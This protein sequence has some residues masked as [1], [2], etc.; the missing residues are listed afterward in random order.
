MDL[1]PSLPAVADP[2]AMVPVPV[3]IPVPDLS[4]AGRSESEI[5]MALQR[6]LAEAGRA[7]G[8]PIRSDDLL[9]HLL[10]EPGPLG[11]EA[12]QAVGVKPERLR[13]ELLRLA[14]HPEETEGE[15]LPRECVPWPLSR[16]AWIAVTVSFFAYPLSVGPVLFVADWLDLESSME[17]TIELVYFP[18]IWLHQ[19]VPWVESFYDWYLRVIGVS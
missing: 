19:S 10:S 6:V 9:A 12:L 2:S 13:A 1:T 5:R 3:P 14:G 7:T 11:Q 16:W 8:R 4:A 17:G 18:I 15:R